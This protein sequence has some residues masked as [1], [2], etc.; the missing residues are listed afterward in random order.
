MTDEIKFPCIT[1]SFPIKTP[2]HKYPS[3]D[4]FGRFRSLIGKNK[5]VDFFASW[6]ISDWKTTGI[7]QSWESHEYGKCFTNRA[8]VRGDGKILSTV[9]SRPTECRRAP[10]F[11]AHVQKRKSELFLCGVTNDNYKYVSPIEWEETTPTLWDI[12]KVR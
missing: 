3:E 7:V 1:D 5:I 10:E 12:E 8:L 6:L 2:P 4:A 11:R 9:N